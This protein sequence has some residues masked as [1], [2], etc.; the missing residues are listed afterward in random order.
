MIVSA[1]AVL[2]SAA[3]SNQEVGALY[4][5]T[6][7]LFIIQGKLTSIG[8]SI[9]LSLLIVLVLSILGFLITYIY[10]EREDLN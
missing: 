10:F 3:L 9:M 7:N 5:Y 6:I 8:Y 2:G 4:P 1:V